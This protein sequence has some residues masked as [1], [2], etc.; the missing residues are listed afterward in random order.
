MASCIVDVEFVFNEDNVIFPQNI[1]IT[2]ITKEKRLFIKK[3][4]Y[5]FPTSRQQN[6]KLLSN[7]TRNTTKFGHFDFTVRN[8]ELHENLRN[9]DFITVKDKVQKAFIAQYCLEK[10]KIVALT[11]KRYGISSE[12]SEQQQQQHQEEEE[13]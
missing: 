7:E 2:G 5:N 8:I 6:V 11:N 4:A 3:I 1:V 10:T 12:T 13:E 9:F